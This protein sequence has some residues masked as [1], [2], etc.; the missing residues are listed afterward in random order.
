MEISPDGNW[1]RSEAARLCRRLETFAPD[2][3][4]HVALTGG[5]LYKD[6]PRKDVDIVVY[7]IQQRALDRKGFIERLR[8]EGFDILG[9]YGWLQKVA[10]PG[11]RRPVDLL[12]PDHKRTFGEWWASLW[13]SRSTGAY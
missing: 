3:G 4:A 13:A 8:R 7:R 5:T 6:G 2:F 12:F 1:T 9:E 11:D 10:T